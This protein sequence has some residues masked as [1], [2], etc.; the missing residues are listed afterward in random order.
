MLQE[1]QNQ[2]STL[3]DDLKTR[4]ADSIQIA[5]AAQLAILADA[6]EYIKL[7]DDTKVV[8]MEHIIQWLSNS[9]KQII[10]TL[11]K[12]CGEVNQNGISNEFD[13]VCSNEECL[14]NFK[15]RVE[16]NPAFF[17]GNR[18]LEQ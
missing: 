5:A 10:D 15:G 18:L 4:Y 17:F 11:Q 9:N 1:I 13:F 2:D 12:I 16:F 8:D 7:P 6:I 14:Q 3:T